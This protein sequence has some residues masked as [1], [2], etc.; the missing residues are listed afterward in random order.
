MLEYWFKNRFFRQKWNLYRMRKKLNFINKEELGDI[1][2]VQQLNSK[3][4]DKATQE[5]KFNRFQQTEKKL[6]SLEQIEMTKN[7]IDLG[8]EINNNYMVLFT[9][10]GYIGMFSGVFPAAATFGF[11]TNL[12]MIYLTELSY[13]TIAKRSLSEEIEGIGVWN[14]IFKAT[15]LISIVVNAMILAFTATTL[16][17]FYSNNRASVFTAIFI[18]EHLLV[19]LLLLLAQLIPD[20]PRVVKYRIRNEK[21][22]ERKEMDRRRRRERRKELRMGYDRFKGSLVVDGDRNAGGEGEV[23]QGTA[24]KEDFNDYIKGEDL[25]DDLWLSRFKEDRVASPKPRVIN[26]P[27]FVP[28]KS[29]LDLQEKIRAFIEK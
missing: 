14:D 10:F 2:T 15:G 4:P 16:N 11:L 25:S 23:V 13:S 20:V 3:F 22:L 24:L 5:A 27:R 7:M 29:K 9:Q 8:Q 12:V 26:Q 21:I 28:S 1:E 17:T 18:G 6:V 19:G